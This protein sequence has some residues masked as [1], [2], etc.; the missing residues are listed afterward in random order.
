MNAFLA[1]CFKEYFPL[2]GV[3]VGSDGWRRFSPLRE[4]MA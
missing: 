3:L 2:P 1:E 4:T